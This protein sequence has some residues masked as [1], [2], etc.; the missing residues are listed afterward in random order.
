MVLS[1]YSVLS[2]GTKKVENIVMGPAMLDLV[3]RMFTLPRPEGSQHVF[4][5]QDNNPVTE[6]GFNSGWGRAKEE[7]KE[8]GII[9][10]NFT[11]HDL[12]AYYTT[13]HKNKFGNCSDK[14]ANSATAAMV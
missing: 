12:R 10:R 4:I 11:F 14:H 6:E 8:M 1:D 2:M 3:H 13:M 9:T 5:N 7:A